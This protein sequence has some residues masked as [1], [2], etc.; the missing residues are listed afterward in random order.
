MQ[1]GLRKQM[2]YISALVAAPQ[3]RFW[4]GWEE[5]TMDCWHC[6]ATSWGFCG[7][8]LFQ[9]IPRDGM[10]F[11]FWKLSVITT[12]KF[13][14]FNS[15]DDWAQRNRDFHQVRIS[16]IKNFQFRFRGGHRD[17][18]KEV[19]NKAGESNREW[20]VSGHSANETELSQEQLQVISKG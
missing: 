1:L 17:L 5:M 8:Q 7:A 18:F 13:H 3:L 9:M 2:L 19:G 16:I 10:I 14:L 12:T 20:E 11:L 4:H 15:S 6:F